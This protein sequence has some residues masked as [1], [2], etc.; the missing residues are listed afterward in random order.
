MPLEEYRSKRVFGQTPEPSGKRVRPAA[1]KNPVFVVQ[2]HHASSPHYDFRLEIDG[3]LGSWAV[4]RGPSLNPVDKRLAI[5]TE[6]HPLEYAEFEG[7]I[8]EGY[9]GAGPVMIWDR[10]PLPGDRRRLRRRTTGARRNQIYPVRS[11]APRR[12]CLGA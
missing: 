9:Y 10:G 7:V 2:K 8:P 12:I 1:R 4:P 6:D 11:K 3:A 5:A